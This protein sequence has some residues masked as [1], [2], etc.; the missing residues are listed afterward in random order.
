MLSTPTPQGG[1]RFRP[2]TDRGPRRSPRHVDGQR[3]RR[4][5][6]RVLIVIV[7]LG[8]AAV[9]LAYLDPTRPERPGDPAGVSWN[10]GVHAT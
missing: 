9:L 5:L 6:I 4:R 10:G 8:I 7:A 3:L 1:P 2:P